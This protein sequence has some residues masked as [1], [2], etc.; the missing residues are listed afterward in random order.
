MLEASL[1][2]RL[3]KRWRSDGGRRSGRSVCRTQKFPQCQVGGVGDQEQLA[4]PT[5]S[6]CG[7]LQMCRKTNFHKGHFGSISTYDH[8]SVRTGHPVRS[9]IHKH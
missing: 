6:G 5:F 9:A 7:R 8:R 3:E 4:L 1:G 2:M